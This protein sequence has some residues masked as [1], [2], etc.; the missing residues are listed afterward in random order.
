MNCKLDSENAR[1]IRGKFVKGLLLY[2][3]LNEAAGHA[4]HD[5]TGAQ[6]AQ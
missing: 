1:E 3:L 4:R 5:R 6:V 2:F